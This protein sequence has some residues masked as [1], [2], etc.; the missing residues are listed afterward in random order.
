MLINCLFKKIFSIWKALNN[1]PVYRGYR[2]QK[3]KK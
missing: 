3:E 1:P 2:R